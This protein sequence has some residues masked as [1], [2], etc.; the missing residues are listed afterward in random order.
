MPKRAFLSFKMEDKK[1]VDGIRL[2]AWSDNHD[3]DFYDESVRVPYNSVNAPYIR[4]KI[5]EKIRRS[6]VTICFL[7]VNTHKSDW[8]N[9]EL[10]KSTELG[11]K[12]GLMGLPR[13]PDALILPSEVAGQTWYLWDPDLLTRW[14]A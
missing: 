11:N 12:I 9:W 8:V 4:S 6:S 3:L 14:L 1:Q 5:S 13:G 10:S 2:M 7:G